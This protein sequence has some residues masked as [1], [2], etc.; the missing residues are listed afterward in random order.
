METFLIL[1]LTKLHYDCFGEKTEMIFGYIFRTYRSC[2][3]HCFKQKCPITQTSNLWSQFVQHWQHAHWSSSVEPRV[4]STGRAGAP[5]TSPCLQQFHAR[6][7]LLHA[8]VWLVLSPLGRRC[9]LLLEN[10]ETGSLF[11]ICEHSIHHLTAYRQQFALQSYHTTR[12]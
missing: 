5:H 11:W 4:R 10:G 12:T 9:F 3:Y 7:Q 8:P 2:E 1:G 6:L